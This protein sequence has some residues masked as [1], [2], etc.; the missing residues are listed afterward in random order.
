MQNKPEHHSSLPAPVSTT[1]TEIRARIMA[2]R[3]DPEVQRRARE[4]EQADARREAMDRQIKLDQC[5]SMSFVGRR[6]ADR[7][8]ANLIATKKNE[9]AIK[10]AHEIVANPMRGV[11]FYGPYGVAKTH[12]AAAIAHAFIARGIP[13]IMNTLASVLLQARGTFTVGSKL[14]EEQFLVRLASVK[15]LILD[16]LGKERISE[17]SATFLWSLI[18]ARYEQNLPIIGTCNMSLEAFTQHYSTPIAGLDVHTLPSML[19]RLNE[20]VSDWVEVGG[21]SHRTRNKG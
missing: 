14:T 5:R 18:N 19:D 11:I 16:D 3:N 21:E 15:V 10:I 17:W 9:K 20:M 8:F 1:I 4:G 7:T 12:I 2:M 6:F 13:A